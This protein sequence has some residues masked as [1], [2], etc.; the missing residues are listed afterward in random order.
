MACRQHPLCEAIKTGKIF[1]N[2]LANW[3][4]FA[5]IHLQKILLGKKFPKNVAHHPDHHDAG[6]WWWVVLGLSGQ[7]KLETWK[8]NIGGLCQA[9][10]QIS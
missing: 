8:A 10:E 1:A 6:V 2:K 7:N 3:V 4:H 9:A 5:K